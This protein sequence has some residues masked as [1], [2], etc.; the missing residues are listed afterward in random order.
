MSAIIESTN[1]LT[2]ELKNRPKETGGKPHPMT[3]DEKAAI[4]QLLSE[5]YLGGGQA[6]GR[7]SLIY[8]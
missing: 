7:Y 5:I 3:E 4:V 1:R 8:R 6:F 2:A